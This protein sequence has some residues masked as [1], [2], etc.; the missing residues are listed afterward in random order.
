MSLKRDLKY[1]A[2]P[3]NRSLVPVRDLMLQVELVAGIRRRIRNGYYTRPDVLAD[4][5]RQLRERI[6][7]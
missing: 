4:I 5:A 1:N 2:P 3:P 7:S 6:E